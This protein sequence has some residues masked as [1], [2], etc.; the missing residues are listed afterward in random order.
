MVL[1]YILLGVVL[2][3]GVTVL[4][5][6]QSMKKH[7]P[8]IDAAKARFQNEVGYSFG[9]PMA[10]LQGPSRKNTPRGVL[11]HTFESRMEGS[12]QVSSQSWTLTLASPS[13]V[14]LQL[15]ERKRL[16]AG[17]ALRNLVSPT[18]LHVS[19]SF[20]GPAPLGDPDLDARFLLFSPNPGVAAQMLRHPALKADLLACAEVLL[21]VTRQVASFGDPTDANL[22]AAYEAAGHSRFAMNPAPMILSGIP[23]HQRIERILLGATQG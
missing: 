13:P 8:A 5:T 14:E 1:L 17:Q 23:V 10:P 21:T 16:G 3:F 2:I 11:V 12:T 15:V 22:W 9:G 20:P 18:S 4:L 6:M 7:K 19:T